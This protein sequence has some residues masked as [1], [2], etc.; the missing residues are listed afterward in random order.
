MNA[1]ELARILLTGPDLPV[2]TFANGHATAIFDTMKVGVLSLGDRQSR[3]VIG[4]FEY[5]EMSA[6]TVSEMLAGD[7]PLNADDRAYYDRKRTEH[8]RAIDAAMGASNERIQKP[9]RNTR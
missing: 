1:H 9:T 3:I 6:G 8:W 5:R 4:N 2:Q 7:A